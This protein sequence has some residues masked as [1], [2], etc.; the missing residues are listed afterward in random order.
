MAQELKIEIPAPNI[1]LIKV[2]IIG[3]SPLIYHKW[4]EKAIKMIEDKQ[5]KKAT[6]GREAR[7]PDAEYKNSFYYDSEG[8]IAFPARN[9]KQAIV[10]SARFLQDVKMTILRGAVFVKGDKDNMIPVIYKEKDKHMRK[11]MV[12][13]GMG[14]ADVRYRGELREWSMEFIIEYD[15]DLMSASQ[16]VNLLQRAG[17]SQGL[18]E[19]RP[20][21]NGD[22]GT[23]EVETEAGGKK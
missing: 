12:T 1:Q 17:F 23:F 18:G 15:G 6:K 9:I 22:N 3:T 19:W 10:G 21:K 13:V 7:D 4:D 16:V 5:Q 8:N 14:S 20:E 2:K 11:D